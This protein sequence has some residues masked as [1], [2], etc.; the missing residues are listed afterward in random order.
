VYLDWN[1]TKWIILVNDVTSQI[2]WQCY[3]LIKA[4]IMLVVDNP[5]GQNCSLHIGS[6]PDFNHF[7]QLI[8][9]LP[10][11]KAFF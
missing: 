11:L 4:E 9:A 1:E 7:P 6:I 2:D 8:T 5:I 3:C 10:A